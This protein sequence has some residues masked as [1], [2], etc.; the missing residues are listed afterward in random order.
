MHSFARYSNDWSALYWLPRAIGPR[1]GAASGATL[2]RDHIIVDVT[3][4]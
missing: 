2:R 3:A 4:A 1:C